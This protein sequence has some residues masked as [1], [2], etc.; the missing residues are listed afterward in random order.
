MATSEE[1]AIAKA[2]QL[3]YPVVLKLPYNPGH[4]TPDEGGRC[5]L[6]LTGQQSCSRMPI[7]KLTRAGTGGHG[8]GSAHAESATGP[9]S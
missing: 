3:G 1:R 8:A 6:N 5:S 2:E 7:D 4:H 9:M